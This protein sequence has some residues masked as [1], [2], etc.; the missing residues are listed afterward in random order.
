MSYT[1]EMEIIAYLV[2]LQLA[3]RSTIRPFYC[4]LIA[5]GVPFL[6]SVVLRYIHASGG[7]LPILINLTTPG[8]L[9]AMLLQLGVCFI[10]FQKLRHEEDL[11]PTVLW[12]AIGFGLVVLA[13]PLTVARFLY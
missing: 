1:R 5:V 11:M 4:A 2:G 12:G 13:I 10:V 8:T 7:D 9:V 3:I 6:S